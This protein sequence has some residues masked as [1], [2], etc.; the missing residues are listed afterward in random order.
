M[1]NLKFAYN[2]HG[3]NKEFTNQ[4]LTN[5]F[6]DVEE[7]LSGLLNH[8]QSG[9]A[10]NCAQLGNR[11]RCGENVQGV[12]LIG[13]DFDNS[14]IAEDGSKVYEPNLTIDQALEH[15]FIRKNACLIY[16]TG[17]H[18]PDWQRLRVLFRLP[19][20]LTDQ[21]YFRDL[22]GGFHVGLETLKT[23]KACKDPCRVFFGNTQ[24]EF[25]LINESAVLPQLWCDA[26]VHRVR[27]ERDRRQKR[28]ER[29]LRESGQDIDRL[30]GD[31]LKLI[32]PR[33]PGSGTYWESLKVLMALHSHYG[34]SAESIAEDWSPSIQGN[35]WQVGRKLRSFKRD[36]GVTIASLFWIAES[37]GWQAPWKCGGVA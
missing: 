12:G 3:C 19:Q 1:A 13:L 4:D 33:Q 30:V 9:H 24:A 6:Q 32:P 20:F 25:P 36:T 34:D 23:D 35:D 27:L 18:T 22:I 2:S 15:R 37:H 17:S 31:A 21:L 28:T 7:P 29:Q 5:W 16:T 14:A 26:V 8:I 10:I 11:R